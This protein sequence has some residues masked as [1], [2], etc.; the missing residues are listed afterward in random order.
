MHALRPA[1]NDLR[2]HHY[3]PNMHRA[4]AIYVYFPVDQSEQ[5]YRLH[6]DSDQSSRAF[7]KEF[8]P[9]HL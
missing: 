9:I 3:T 7:P 5:N 2:V 4:A 6:R 8:L 1:I